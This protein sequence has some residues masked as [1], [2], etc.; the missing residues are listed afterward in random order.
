[1]LMTGPK[2]METVQFLVSSLLALVASLFVIAV[3]RFL[4][5]LER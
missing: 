2:N 3:I 4:D 5:L 1:M